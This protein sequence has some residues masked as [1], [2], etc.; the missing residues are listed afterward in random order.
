MSRTTALRNT[1]EKIIREK[2]ESTSAGIL[3]EVNKRTKNGS[4][5]NQ[6]G[7]LLSRDTRFV[8]VDFLSVSDS[9]IINGVGISQRVRQ[10][11][12]ALDEDRDCTQE[13]CV[14][15]EENCPFNKVGM[16]ED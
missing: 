11:V 4:S 7:N 9:T 10:C 13:D 3:E 2:G 5:M 12:W 6:I 1:I 15:N 14:C 16:E 8:K